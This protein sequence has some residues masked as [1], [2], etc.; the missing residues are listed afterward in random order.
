MSTF[1]G[2]TY[3]VCEDDFTSY[4]NGVGRGL[5]EPLGF[6]CPELSVSSVLVVRMVSN[7][8]EGSVLVRRVYSYVRTCIVYGK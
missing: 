3:E 7:N 6:F 5:T 1:R 2:E 4:L 8:P